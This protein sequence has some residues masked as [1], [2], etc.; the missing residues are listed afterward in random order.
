MFIA[1]TDLHDLFA[2]I[3]QSTERSFE[4]WKYSV[5]DLSSRSIS[6]ELDVE[7]L[8]FVLRLECRDKSGKRHTCKDLELEIFKSGVDVNITLFW[9]QREDYP[10]L[11]QGN[12]S[13]WMDCST[14]KLTKIPVDGS[15]LEALAR[16]LRALLT[17]Y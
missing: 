2:Q 6:G 16:R 15:S 14:G 11:W 4:P 1:R 8:D 9:V 12:H 5:V 17:N 13:V 3:A 7:A 10:I